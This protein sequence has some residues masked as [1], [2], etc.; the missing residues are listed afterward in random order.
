MTTKP[1]TSLFIK[2]KIEHVLD[3]DLGKGNFLIL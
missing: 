1:H 3:I 2:F